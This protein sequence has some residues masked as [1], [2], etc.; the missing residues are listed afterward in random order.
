MSIFQKMMAIA[1]RSPSGKAR[2]IKTD[3]NGIVQTKPD[4]IKNYPA[5]I[6]ETKTLSGSFP[7]NVLDIQHTNL[8]SPI[9]IDSIIISATK[10]FA[11][12]V[13]TNNSEG[14][15]S[16]HVSIS[17]SQV[18]AIS[19]NPSFQSIRDGVLPGWEM[20]REEDGFYIIKTTQ[21]IYMPFGGRVRL[22]RT[23]ADS[24]VAVVASYKEL[25]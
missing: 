5:V 17:P 20:V 13:E 21:P 6:R 12:L 25:R 4:I 16:T 2:A 11:V 1:G 15:R 24:I 7:D 23:I 22:Q 18:G 14:V 19:N 3:E 8:N 9:Q 10:P